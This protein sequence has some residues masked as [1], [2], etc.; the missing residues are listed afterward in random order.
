MGQSAALQ[1]VLYNTE[2][3]F[4]ANASTFGTAL[5]LV[6]TVDLSNL[7]RKKVPLE[8]IKQYQ[9][10][11]HHGSLAPFDGQS[12]TLKGRLTG[13]GATTTGA[14]PASDLWTFLGHLIGQLVDG[15]TPGGTFTGGTA[16]APATSMASGAAA[17]I[18]A[19]GGVV[20]DG[21]IGGQWLAVNTHAASAMGLFIAAAAAPS[22]GDLLYSNKVLFP[23]EDP[24]ETPGS[25]RMQIL[26]SNGHFIVRGCFL[27]G[28]RITGKM[29]GGVLDWEMDLGV[30]HVTT[31]SATFPSATVPQRH[32]SGPA[33][34]NGSVVIQE[35][36]VTTHA[37]YIVRDMTLEF[38]VG[39]APVFG[40]G[41]TFEG[42]IITGIVRKTPATCG[43]KITMVVDAEATGT[44]TWRDRFDAD[45]NT[46]QDYYQVLAS[47]LVHDGRAV[48]L[49]AGRCILAETQ[50]IQM[51]HDG[52]NRVRLTF[53]ATTRTTESSTRRRASWM[54]GAA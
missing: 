19:R 41:G 20:G 26:T 22:N 54:L 53:H 36:G 30:A 38:D 5:P 14:V 10:E 18:L 23:Y 12:L 49:Y 1:A 13:L 51:D 4:C 47:L 21:R 24:G 39:C 33:L 34:V 3:S 43:L 45:P 6:G 42:Q 17:S 2:A 11:R 25:V 32:A 9:N 31:T 52:F 35:V 48:G 27:L 16:A 46:A 28:F 29:P 37:A 40:P 50:P 44:N 8:A 7:A 15:L